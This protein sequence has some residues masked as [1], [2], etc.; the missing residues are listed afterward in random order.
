MK[1]A[2]KV[3]MVL[4]MLLGVAVTISNL[5]PVKLDAGATFGTWIQFG[6][7]GVCIGTPV[8]CAV[9]TPDPSGD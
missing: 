6:G 3:L 1:K 5:I 2:L 7:P 4:L 9:V 8:D